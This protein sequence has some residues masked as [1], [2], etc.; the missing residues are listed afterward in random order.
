MPS[1]VPKP[2]SVILHLK[3][4]V[5]DHNQVSR[6][7]CQA[8]IN[9]TGN[10]H[11]SKKSHRQ[12]KVVSVHIAGFWK[13]LSALINHSGEL[14]LIKGKTNREH[15]DASGRRRATTGCSSLA[16]HRLISSLSFSTLL[17]IVSVGGGEG[18]KWKHGESGRVGGVG[19]RRER[20]NTLKKQKRG[21]WPLR[22][23]WDLCYNKAR[24]QRGR[25]I[26]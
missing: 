26:R 6:K 21:G 2:S 18:N 12:S 25:Y 14:K 4:N 11:I 5:F 7:W 19:E 8:F 22:G 9:P 1:G 10:T 3:K 23:L 24:R 16:F 15:G 20:K 13:S 17:H